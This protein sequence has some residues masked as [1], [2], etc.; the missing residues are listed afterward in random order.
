MI[1]GLAPR[2]EE[3]TFDFIQDLFSGLVEETPDLAIVPDVAH[4]WEIKDGG[5]TYLFHL[6][7]DVYWSDGEPVTA[8]DFAFAWKHNRLPNQASGEAA[9]RGQGWPL[10]STTASQPICKKSM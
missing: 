4:R 9:L 2:N 5:W 6:R 1:W 8:L 10:C 3:P 7:D